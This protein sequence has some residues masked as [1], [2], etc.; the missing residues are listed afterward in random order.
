[1]NGCILQGTLFNC[2]NHYRTPA[3]RTTHE[4]CIKASG[5]FLLRLEQAPQKNQTTLRLGVCT[6]P[7]SL[8]FFLHQRQRTKRAIKREMQR[9]RIS[10]L[11][12][13]GLQWPFVCLRLGA[14]FPRSVFLQ[15]TYHERNSANGSRG[16]GHLSCKAQVRTV[17]E[18]VSSRSRPHTK[19]GQ[20]PPSTP[21]TPQ[22][23]NPPTPQ[24]PNPPTPQPPN[25]P[26][27]Q[28]P[29]PPTPQPPNPPTPQPPNPPTPAP[30][31]RGTKGSR[32]WESL[33]GNSIH[34]GF[35][36]GVNFVNE[37]QTING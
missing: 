1:M 14:I 18:A 28:P 17:A 10:A 23:P 32:A 2:L 29:N 6:L 12:L 26:T 16:L 8:P 30:N 37:S 4:G 11:G 5:V 3:Q 33:M 22:P 35:T 31:P 13:P 24:P 15:G 25:P 21:P 34:G 36:L 27:P 19:N 9:H 20:P 7:R